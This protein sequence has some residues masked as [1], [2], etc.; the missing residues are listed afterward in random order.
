MERSGDNRAVLPSCLLEACGVVVL[1]EVFAS[2]PTPP[3][4][5]EEKEKVAND[6][7]DH[8]WQQAISGEFARAA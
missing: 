6:V 1:D 4:T 2:L 3:F 8:I 7:Y 5:S